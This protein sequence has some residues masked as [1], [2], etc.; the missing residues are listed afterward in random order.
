[1]TETLPLT[2]RFVSVIAA[3][4]FIVGRKMT[5][6]RSNPQ[7]EARRTFAGGFLPRGTL[8]CEPEKKGV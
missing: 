5:A 7:D 6:E 3:T 4:A 2:A 8:A 1:V